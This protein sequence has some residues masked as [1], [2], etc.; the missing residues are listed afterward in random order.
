MS[1]HNEWS[2]LFTGFNTDA[3]IETKGATLDIEDMKHAF[4]AIRQWR[5]PQPLW[6]PCPVCG[7]IVECEYR[8]PRWYIPCCESDDS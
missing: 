8:H 2:D 3:T 6:A 1:K 5:D 7:R 4:D